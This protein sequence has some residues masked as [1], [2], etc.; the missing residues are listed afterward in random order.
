MSSDDVSN[1]SIGVSDG[2]VF[3]NL[4]AVEGEF[5]VRTLHEYHTSSEGHLSFSQY[6]Y[7]KVKHCE[8]SGWW[9]GESENNRGW[10]PR[11]RVERVDTTYETEI[12]SEDY[13]QIRTGLDGVETQFL[14]EPVTDLVSDSMQ[15]DWG[16]A[17]SPSSRAVGVRTR[18]GQLAF[19]PSQISAIPQSYHVLE[20]A[21]MDIEHNMYHQQA[22]ASTAPGSAIPASAITLET[23]ANIE[24]AFPC[25]YS[26]FV[27]E[28]S[29]YVTE[30]RDAASRGEV[31]RYQPIVANLI[32]CVKAL[33]VFTNTI[34]RDSEVLLAYPELSSSR[35]VILRGLGKLYSKCRVANGSQALTTSRQRQFAVEK[36]GF[37]A[38]QVLDG[39][40]DFT[41]RARE[42]GLRLTA[43]SVSE[44][45]K[46]GGRG[47]GEEE[48]RRGAATVSTVLGSNMVVA[49][50][51]IERVRSITND[52][53]SS[54]TS[55]PSHGR[56]RRRVSR[57]SSARG[58]KSFNAVRQWKV[59]NQQKYNTARKAVEHILAEYME[60]LN[61]GNG[62]AGLDRILRMTIQSAQTVEIFLASADEM[63]IRTN[64]KDDGIYAKHR[65]ELSSTLRELLNFIR[66]LETAS[67]ELSTSGD[68]VLNRFMTL[69]SALLRCLVDLEAHSKPNAGT[70]ESPRVTKRVMSSSPE[71][72]SEPEPEVPKVSSVIAS[73]TVS[74]TEK[75]EMR[76]ASARNANSNSGDLPP[77]TMS[78]RNTAPPR[79]KRPEGP[80]SP[81]VVP[82]G[83]KFASLTSLNDCYKQQ[84]GSQQPSDDKD[85]SCL[86]PEVAYGEG[87]D[88]E[89]GYPA[90]YRANH[91]SAVALMSAKNT[92]HH[93]LM[94]DEKEVPITDS[95][96]SQARGS[97]RPRRLQEP[98][99]DNS[100]D[101]DEFIKDTE[102]KVAAIFMLNV[103]K[104]SLQEDVG[105]LEPSGVPRSL[106]QERESSATMPSIRS[107]YTPDESPLSSS[108]AARTYSNWGDDTPLPQLSAA[109]TSGEGIRKD[110]LYSPA[111]GERS[112]TEDSRI[113]GLG[114]N[115]PRGTR[116]RSSS[117]APAL[118]ET[119]AAPTP[120]PRPSAIAR[121]RSPAASNSSRLEPSR[122]IPRPEYSPRPSSPGRSTDS[123]GPLSRNSNNSSNANTITN[124]SLTPDSGS[125]RGSQTS[126]YS[127]ASRK[128]SSSDSLQPKDHPERT[129]ELQD[130]HQNQQQR[131][132]SQTGPWST[133]NAGTTHNDN[134]RHKDQ[135]DGLLSGLAT[136]TTPS[137]QSFVEGHHQQQAPRRPGKSHRR[138]SNASNA[139]IATENITQVQAGN[140]RPV[141]PGLRTRISQ[142]G[143]HSVTAARGRASSESVA[144]N[145]RY[146]SPRLTQQ[147]FSQRSWQPRVD[148]SGS[149]GEA[150]GPN[151]PGV[152]SRHNKVNP[153]TDRASSELKQDVAMATPW[154]LGNDYNADEVLYNDNGIMVA[155]TLDAYIEMLTSHRSTPDPM[156]VTTFFTTFRLFMTPEELVRYLVQRFILPSPAGLA[157][158][159]RLSWQQQKQDRIQK[160]VYIAFKTWLDGYWV[161]E[162]DRDA[163]RPI[164]EF[165]AHDLIKVL[166]AQ[167]GRLLDMLNQWANKRKSLLLN[168]RSPSISKSRSHER[169]NRV[170]QDSQNTVLANS[171]GDDSSNSKGP[172]TLTEKS[173]NGQ[174]RSVG[175]KGIAG[176]SREN[177]QVRGPP[178]PQVTKA[179]LTALSSDSSMVKVP[180]T[181][182]KAVEMARQL[183]VMVGKMLLEIPYLELL[184]KER[185]NC[186]RMIQV[187]NKITIWV[188]DTIV[189]E[190]D[191]KRRIEVIQY[192]IEVGEECLKLN[193]FDTL[194][195][196]SCAIESTPVKRLN[197]T[198]EGVSKSYLD[199]FLLLKKTV[200]SELNY[201][202]YRAKLKT[203]QAP[204]IPFL[205]LYFTVIA[206]IEDGN[207][208]YKEVNPATTTTT[209]ASSPSAPN[210][211]SSAV[212]QLNPPS[213]PTP[214][215]TQKLLRYG[216][217]SQLT[218]AVQEFHEFQGTYDLLEVPRLTDYILKCMENL[219]SERSYRKSLAIEPRRTAIPSNIPGGSNNSNGHGTNGGHNNGGDFQRTSSGSVRGGSG[220]GRTTGVLGQ[221]SSGGN[222]GLF[223]SGISTSD[224][225][226][227]SSMPAKLNKFFR[228]SARND[229]P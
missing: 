77:Q 108:G 70:P 158:Q 119:T 181:D 148:G 106:K 96:N 171:I 200:S 146:Q 138:E 9:F 223:Y 167:A 48:E 55:S 127:D 72:E 30:L 193:N 40:T 226:G 53:V 51:E 47:K 155:A 189:D 5:I 160:R 11:N 65:A 18:A 97:S 132:P 93:S 140:L 67:D 207:S 214:V 143:G 112:H 100:K 157:D 71:P 162:K 229:R 22:G 88:L 175:R 101:T 32:S 21:S 147:Q 25:P 33:L 81:A 178:V 78:T 196:I 102:R 206:Y 185:P 208:V 103:E 15:N 133:S 184:A 109:G 173:S 195:A 92:P 199:R 192:W 95:C 149:G 68:T 110:R 94:G 7:I 6:Q 188:T 54:P 104:S 197:N 105:T 39:I 165:V 31:D 38:A 122:R 90:F 35:S 126:I 1:S 75:L 182:I 130:K 113:V 59:D 151:A 85:G 117:S 98:E 180:I 179:L 216:R 191:V 118:G 210:S 69:A 129:Q 218:K 225:N 57:A 41:T 82:L 187:S 174:L 156:F 2:N 10:F 170:S 29:L 163:F 28:V 61:G 145:D 13:D 83:R 202:V 168:G 128:R 91:D 42:I 219:D 3:T 14:G 177:L 176:F 44:S 203:V 124:H 227:S 125:R 87:N 20:S 76:P 79:P 89:K 198:W 172:T 111:G 46:T 56:P 16:E 186:S 74:S 23:A 154:Y 19:P 211:T 116:L 36:L 60:C 215:S 114:V 190:S 224:V 139:G 194:T 166:P 144:M 123:R 161:W 62:T 209:A 107:Q 12:T 24:Q 99:L 86:S 58:Y 164:T 183:T 115:V 153:V 34:S 121:A 141:S 73:T 213:T 142:D 217:F 212:S 152:R 220:G 205:G 159:E 134:I 66:I 84:A 228:K 135:E 17:N 8:A 150:N 221:R 120:A 27:K 26:D 137:I 201:S 50:A 63:R 45:A 222:K 131:W 52:V 37:F 4:C 49:G 169:M 136:P 43:E 80:T 64:A 204:C